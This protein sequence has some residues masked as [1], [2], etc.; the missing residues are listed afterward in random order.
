MKPRG[1]AIKLDQFLKLH[2]VVETGG[3][4]KG[5]IQSGR[6]EVNGEIETR[7]GKKLEP[8]DVVEVAGRRLVVEADLDESVG[9]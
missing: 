4:A 7:R 5:L 8:G 2:G 9:S 6:V 3:Q 1:N